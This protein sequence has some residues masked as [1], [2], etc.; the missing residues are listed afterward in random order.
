MAE[1][2]S[3][4]DGN[5]SLLL[6]FMGFHAILIFWLML[7]VPLNPA[8]LKAIAQFK[9]LQSGL[10]G[11]CSIALIFLNRLGSP[12]IKAAL[13]FW[14]SKYPYPG[15]RAFSK[16][17]QGDDRIQMEK[18][19]RAVGGELPHDPKSQNIAWYKLYQV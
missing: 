1:A 8:D 19:R 18:L 5:L 16:L 4:K 15:C 2:K 11:I 14:K 10:I 6:S 9:W 3:L 12:H 17:A 13:V 7:D